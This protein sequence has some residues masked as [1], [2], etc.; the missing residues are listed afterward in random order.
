MNIRWLLHRNIRYFARYYRLVAMAVV[1]TVAVIVGSLVV[2]DSVRMTLVRRVTERLGNTETIIFSRSSFISD[3]I[4]SVSLLGESARG[5]LLTD[6]FISRNGKLVPVF[7]S[8]I[9][10]YRKVRPKS[11]RLCRRNSDWRLRKI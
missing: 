3:S 10:R 8:M 5:V 2:G 11:T 1:I 4:L 7:V 9:F 6:G